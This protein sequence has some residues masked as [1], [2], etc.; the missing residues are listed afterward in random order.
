MP[1][2]T[3]WCLNGSWCRRRLA[4]ATGRVSFIVSIPTTLLAPV[5]I[6]TAKV[7]ESIAIPSTPLRNTPTDK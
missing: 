4:V 1:K 7:N 5:A 2:E 3:R 6:E